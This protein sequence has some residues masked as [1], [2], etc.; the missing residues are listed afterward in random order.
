MKL[1]TDKK[2][3][4]QYLN[5]ELN[6]VSIQNYNDWREWSFNRDRPAEEVYDYNHILFADNRNEYR[7][8]F[9]APT[10][11]TGR[12][13]EFPY[14]CW[15]LEFEGYHF[16]ILTAA[17][18]GTCYERIINPTDNEDE[19]IKKKMTIKFAKEIYK[20]LKQISK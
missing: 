8:L 19:Y 14:K 20:Q 18:K 15:V 2:L 17:D 11:T 5:G 10:F 1:I 7:Q 6:T 16:L 3:R 4:K 13:L 12:Q 9:G